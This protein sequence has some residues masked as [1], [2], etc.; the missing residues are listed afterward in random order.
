MFYTR[1]SRGGDLGDGIVLQVIHDHSPALLHRPRHLLFMCTSVCVIVREDSCRG[2]VAT[3]Q[4]HLCL[5]VSRARHLPKGPRKSLTP[6]QATSPR[7][8]PATDWDSELVDLPGQTPAL[9]ADTGARGK[10]RGSH[11]R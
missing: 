9:E 8:L 10:A 3:C 5:G 6:P 11:H 7:H 2:P 1:R 4:R